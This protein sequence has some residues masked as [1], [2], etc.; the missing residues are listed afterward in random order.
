LQNSGLAAVMNHGS[1]NT[2]DGTFWGH[3]A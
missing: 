2:F 1:L 3:N